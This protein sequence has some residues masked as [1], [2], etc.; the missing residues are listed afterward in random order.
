MIASDVASGGG[1]CETA[2]QLQIYA[3]DD[4]VTMNVGDLR[5]R[6]RPAARRRFRR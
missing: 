6:R 1:N 3:P 5:R 4:T 2:A